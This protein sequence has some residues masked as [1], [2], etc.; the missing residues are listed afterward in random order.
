MTVNN[1]TEEYDDE[2]SVR[3]ETF[4]VLCSYFKPEPTPTPAPPDNSGADGDSNA[5]GGE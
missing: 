3:Y 5:E 2:T 4:T 1:I